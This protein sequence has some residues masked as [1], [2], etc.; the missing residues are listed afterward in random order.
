MMSGC[1]KIVCVPL[2]PFL[3]SNLY[4]KKMK[5]IILM[6]MAV[7]AGYAAQAQTKNWLDV[8]YVEVMGKAELEIVPNE[9]YVDIVI[10]EQDNKAKKSAEQLER[11][12][13]TALQKIG[14]DVEKDLRIRD[15]NSAFRKFW[16]KSDQIYTSKEYQLLVR[17]AADLGK[18]YQAIET[19]GISNLKISRV[20]HSEIERYRREVKANAA[21]DAKQKASDLAAAV[22]ETLGACLHLQEI[23]YVSPRPLR[24]MPMRSKSMAFDDA[25]GVEAE[26][27]LE[28]EKIKIEYSVSAQFAIKNGF[29]EVK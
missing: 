2:Q 24:A 12:M 23:D 8:P 28:F 25:S 15:M 27:E 5:R 6:I 17:S 22:G 29:K 13:K 16:Y 20:T 26:P 9:I 18:A 4:P 10:S 7:S 14:I 21:K 19:A 11:E 3:F 1:P